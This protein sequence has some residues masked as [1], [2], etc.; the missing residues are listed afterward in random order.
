MLYLKPLGKIDKEIVKKLTRDLEKKL[1]TPCQVLSAGK[2]PQEAF[3][4]SR[5]QYLASQVLDYLQKSVTKRGK[6]LGILDVDLYSPSLNFVFGQA[7]K[8]FAVL[9]LFRLKSENPD[10]FYQRILKEAAH[11]RGH[12]FGL[13]HCSNFCLMRFCNSLFEVDQ[14]PAEFCPLCRKRLKRVKVEGDR[15]EIKA[16]IKF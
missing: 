2:V 10:V 12:T 1:E 9:S 4:Y 11:E 14:K 8:D 7:T 13:S 6:I 16:K 15:L 3:N 5:N